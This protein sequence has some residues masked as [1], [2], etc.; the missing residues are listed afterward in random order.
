MLTLTS[1]NNYTNAK[2]FS[3][4]QTTA[5]LIAVI[6]VFSSGY[7]NAD[8]LVK[9]K[10]LIEAVN[11][12]RGR[13]SLLDVTNAI[14]DVK[15]YV[16]SGTSSNNLNTKLDDIKTYVGE[17]TKTDNL[18]TKLNFLTQQFLT[19]KKEFI[20]VDSITYLKKYDKSSA[21]TVNCAGLKSDDYKSIDSDKITNS[22]AKKAFDASKLLAKAYTIVKGTASSL[23]ETSPSET[24][25]T[26]LGSCSYVNSLVTEMYEESNAFYV[27]IKTLQE[28]IDVIAKKGL[29]PALVNTTTTGKDTFADVAVISL[30]LQIIQAS[31]ANA[32]GVHAANVEMFKFKIQT[33]KENYMK[34]AIKK[35]LG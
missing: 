4:K 11:D 8:W 1:C 29:T 10:T 18:N 23:E 13:K 16:G 31:Q 19:I 30:E 7:A 24:A 33:A 17:G 12:M 34:L 35:L 25:K 2:K 3:L 32:I 9:D 27:H 14:N 28:K 5:K 15:T 26:L 20:K 22:A 6:T 21:P